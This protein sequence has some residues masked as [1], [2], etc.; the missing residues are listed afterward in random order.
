M[1][2]ALDTTRDR[3]ARTALLHADCLARAARGYQS[4]E[5][6][7]WLITSSR[8]ILDRRR[9]VFSGGGPDTITEPMIRK[10]LRTLID[11]GVLTPAGVGCFWEWTCHQR[12]QCSGCGAAIV[13][14][15]VEVEVSTRG[16][17][18]L[19]LHGR[20]LELWAQ[21][22]GP[23]VRSEPERRRGLA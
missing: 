22:A 3:I 1:V 14:G 15:E 19:F 23:S 5:R 10:R 2:L 18:V 8:A 16:G 21:E 17:V 11:S 6:A 20:C 13:P 12:H 7:Q 4:M 9:P